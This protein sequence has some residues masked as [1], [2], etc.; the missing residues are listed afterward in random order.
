MNPKDPNAIFP[1][2]KP[3]TIIDFRNSSIPNAGKEF[4]GAYRKKKN[5]AI[6]E[7]EP[8]TIEEIIEEETNNN[9][10]ET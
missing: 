7:N 1:K 8:F 5:L 6:T 2:Y 9:I 4:S 3:Q 10:Q